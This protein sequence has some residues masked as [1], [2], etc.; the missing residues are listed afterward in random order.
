MVNPESA[1]EG[2]DD[3]NNDIDLLGDPLSH[4]N[5]EKCFKDDSSSAGL[6]E[7]SV[8][9]EDGLLTTSSSFPHSK[10][11]K[12]KPGSKE[13]VAFLSVTVPPSS[14]ANKLDSHVQLKDKVDEQKEDPF[15]SLLTG[16]NKKSSIF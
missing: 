14:T 2:P 6:P 12:R 16:G 7:K 3:T 11:L 8:N 1:P 5:E 10:T 13:R 15:F 4:S 9:P